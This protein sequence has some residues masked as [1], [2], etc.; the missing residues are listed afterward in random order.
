[1]RSAALGN[2]GFSPALF[3]PSTSVVRYLRKE[4]SAPVIT[5]FAGASKTTVVTCSVTITPGTV[6]TLQPNELSV[7]DVS[8]AHGKLAP[9]SP[10]Q[11]SMATGHEKLSA[12]WDTGA[13]MCFVSMNFLR[14]RSKK[15]LGWQCIKKNKL[16]VI[17]EILVPVRRHDGSRGA[18][19]L[20]NLTVRCVD[21]RGGEELILGA[22][23]L[24]CFDTTI[25]WSGDA[26]SIHLGRS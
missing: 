26:W 19:V 17:P 2:D 22:P 25:V 18:L 10:I 24:N 5:G 20:K 7:C 16:Y 9:F 13:P 4:P 14:M 3:G 11:V 12:V 8:H 23:V 21:L 1:M 15:T 6:A